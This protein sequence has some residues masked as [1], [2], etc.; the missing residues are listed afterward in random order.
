MPRRNLYTHELE[1]E[2]LKITNAPRDELR[3]KTEAIKYRG[4]KVEELPNGREIVITKPGGKLSFGR[5]RREDFLVWI[6]NVDEGTLWLISHKDIYTDLVEKG[7]TSPQDTII[8]INALERVYKGEELDDE[9]ISSLPCP[10][11]EHPAVLLKA[12]KW[13]WAQE[14]TNYPTGLGRRMSWE[15]WKKDYDSGEFEK[16]GTGI[17]DVRENLLPPS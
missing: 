4:Y 16:T 15:G 10:S 3:Q 8:I 12:Y 14:D 9:F 17:Q 7:E 5:P 11:G 1:T 13:I 2:E 6:H